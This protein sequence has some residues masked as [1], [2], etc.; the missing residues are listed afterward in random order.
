[1][2]ILFTQQN[3]MLKLTACDRHRLA[4][5][6]AE[7]AAGD[8]FQIV[9]SGTTLVELSKI[10]GDG[11]IEISFD[12]SMLVKSNDFI[13]YSRIL[14]GTY[15]ETARLIP[16]S[17]TTEVTVNKQE[18]ASALGRIDIVAKESKQ[19]LMK[20]SI[21]Q[22]EITIE[23]KEQTKRARETVDV[24]G[25]VGDEIAIGINGKYL[26]DALKAI[27]A[28]DLEISLN[29]KMNPIIVRG[30]GELDFHVVLPYRTE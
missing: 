27:G 17:F 23:S 10:I 7:N 22:N 24:K 15:P 8:N 2:G 16:A 1:M 14:E 26:S 19:N 20:L 13:F 12:N 18:L 30:K 3:G 21:N 5:I 4:Q 29:G 28:T 11:D 9:V 25:F 6:E